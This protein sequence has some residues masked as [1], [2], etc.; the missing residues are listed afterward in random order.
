M[1]IE[2]LFISKMIHIKC[3]TLAK[4]LWTSLLVFGRPLYFPI[5]RKTTY[6]DLI[7]A[8]TCLEKKNCELQTKNLFRTVKFWVC[9]VLM[10]DCKAGS[11]VGNLVFIDGHMTAMMYVDILHARRPVLV[12]WIQRTA[13]ICSRTPIQSILRCALANFC[14]TT[15]LVGS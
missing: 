12:N 10:W 4:S 2:K 15:R 14:C 1:F 13:S 5:N 3:L 9:K 11:G 8:A 7:D 6:L